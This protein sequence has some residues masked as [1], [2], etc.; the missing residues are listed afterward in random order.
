MFHPGCFNPPRLNYSDSELREG[1]AAVM[2]WVL[3]RR[4]RNARYVEEPGRGQP[5]SLVRYYC[6]AAE[7]LAR[8][9]AQFRADFGR[10]FHRRPVPSPQG[11]GE[12]LERDT[13][14][15]EVAR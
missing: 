1:E 15:D 2:A 5:S 9:D 13:R 12:T 10:D 14:H 7:R 11:A 6:D 8:E 3:T 4:W